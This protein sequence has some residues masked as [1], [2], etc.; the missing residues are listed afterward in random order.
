MSYVQEVITNLNKKYSQQ[1]EFIQAVSEV[2]LSLE[3]TIKQDENFYRKHRVLERLIVPERI[4]E[5]KVTWIDDNQN[6]QVNTGY[7]IQHSS[8]LGPYKGGLRFH[9]NVNQ[10][11]LKFLAFEQTFKNALT[12]LPLG[13]A[14]GGSDFDP[15]DKS[16]TEI[17]N[18]CQHYMSELY[19]Y[20]GPNIDIPAGDIGVGAREIG[21]LFGHYKKLTN[22]FEGVLTSKGLSYGGSLGR[23]EA[24]GYGVIYMLEEVLKQKNDKIENKVI[25]VSGSGNVAI[26]AIEKALEL[27]AKVVTAS[28]SN[29]WILDNDGI[30][31][32]ILKEIK[33]KKRQ[34]LSEYVNHKPSA[35]YFSNNDL[36]KTPVDVFIPCATQN[37]VTLDDAIDMVTNKVKLVIEGANMPLTNEAVG[38][39]QSHGV[40]YVPGKASNSGGVLV[41]GYEMSQNASKIT[42]SLEEVDSK[43]REK[44][45][46]MVKDMNRV[47]D[48]EYPNNYLKAANVLG[49][50]KL[51]EALISQGV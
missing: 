49:F 15:K 6:I 7:R 14:K 3:S 32:D 42:W 45:I 30:D 23:T 28:D 33:L 11:V 16:D 35:L 36:W 31:L 4:I 27:R 22:R 25:G 50:K 37:E 41:S 17:M 2:L 43:L 10:S 5:F 8:V 19:K 18:F 20:I 26:H 46:E 1:P 51:A 39:L 24:T 12:G 44:M 47:M 29:G 13:G 48:P 9:A 34:R 38:Y 21:Y 40:V